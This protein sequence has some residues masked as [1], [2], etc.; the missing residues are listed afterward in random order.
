MAVTPRKHAPCDDVAVFRVDLG[1]GS[2]IPDHACGIIDL[3]GRVWIRHR[4]LSVLVTYHR[5]PTA[6]R[7]STRTPSMLLMKASFSDVPEGSV[8]GHM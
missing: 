2:N 1:T 8:S 5:L 4:E 7:T 6:T 3:R